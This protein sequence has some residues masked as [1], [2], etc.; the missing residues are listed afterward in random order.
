MAFLA[1]MSG[2]F[3]RAVAHLFSRH[4]GSGEMKKEAPLIRY[5]EVHMMEVLIVDDDRS[6]AKLFKKAIEEWGYSA[7]MVYTGTEALKKLGQKSFDLVLLDIVLPDGQG[8]HLIPR[9][10]GLNPDLGIIAITGFNTR[11][12]E[13]EVRKAGINQYLSKPV[14]MD[15]LRMSVDH[16]AGRNHGLPGDRAGSSE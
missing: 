11:E 2:F 1:K 15:V 3:N 14:G 16:A 8:H 7:E 5:E 9:M 13:I 10:R 12:L 4:R 6:L